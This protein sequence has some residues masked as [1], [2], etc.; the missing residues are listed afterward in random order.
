MK[1]LRI[2][3]FG[4]FVVASGRL[5]ADDFLDQVDEA[6]TFNAFEGNVR[7][8]LSGLLDLELYA[9]DQP[10]PGL[11]YTY[12]HLLANPRLTMFFDTQFGPHAY[13]FVQGR[14][15]RDFDPADQDLQARLDEYA[16]RITPWE[17]GPFVAQ[18]GKFATVVGNYVQ[19]HLSWDN[20]FINAPL[21][22][23]NL[24]P[25]SDI[26]EPY[27]FTGLHLEP[28]ENLPL[29][30]GPSYASGASIAGK[31]G[32]F[33]Y[34]VEIKNSGLA[35]RPQSW[36]LTQV[37]LEN[38]TF[39]GRLGFDPDEAWSFGFS[40]SKGPY[41]QPDV[42]GLP[43]GTGIGDYDEILIGQDIRYAWHHLQIWAEFYEVR[44][45]VPYIGDVDTF[46]YY[47]EA[48]YKLTPEFYCALRWNQQ[49]YGAI[50]D[51]LGEMRPWGSDI[52]RIDAAIG[53]RFSAH[54]QLKVQYSFQDATA[55]S[56]NLIQ[57]LA[58][59]FTVRF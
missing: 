16:L 50:P 51:G 54:T 29:I 9:I 41:F 20:P 37:G 25:I 27:F 1:T 19:R 23:E 43:L 46:A 31:V 48:K 18:I 12:H 21:P 40:A 4:L 56:R 10:P 11:I 26:E 28:E 7:G 32:K 15:D 5:G 42:V 6:L 2:L 52:W 13:L 59:Q 39:S 8:R 24:T 14:A 38:P 53:Y 35:S 34:A 55:D 49:F 47:V 3:C 45:Q 36:D 30:W 17:S 22:Y 33:Q 57:M 58:T 44:F